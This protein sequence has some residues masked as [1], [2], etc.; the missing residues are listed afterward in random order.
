MVNYTRTQRYGGRNQQAPVRATPKDVDQAYTRMVTVVQQA[1]ERLNTASEELTENIYNEPKDDE[2]VVKAKI[3]LGQQMRQIQDANAQLQ[4]MLLAFQPATQKQRNYIAGLYEQLG[5]KGAVISDN[6]SKAEASHII[7]GLKMAATKSDKQRS[8]NIE[9][10][11]AKHVTL[12][13]FA[14]KTEEE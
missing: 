8:D 14:A 11:R 13:N 9:S 1:A 4:D 6:L 12:D 5:A 7:S 2:V 10:E 3:T